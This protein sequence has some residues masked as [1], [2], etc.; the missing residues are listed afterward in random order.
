MSSS[1]KAELMDSVRE[2]VAI[3]TAQD[4]LDKVTNKCFAKCV[5]KPGTSLD[6]SETKCLNFCV[7]RFFDA[8]T[9]VQ[10]TYG[11]RIQR[12]AASGGLR[13]LE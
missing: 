6:S 3:Q 5:S 8:L 11:M 1:Q 2:Q 13:D 12:S 9:V 10:N 4:L 7:D